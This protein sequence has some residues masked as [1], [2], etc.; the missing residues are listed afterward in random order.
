MAHNKAGDVYRLFATDDSSAPIGLAVLSNVNRIRKTADFWICRFS[1]A[2]THRRSKG[3][4]VRALN[5]MMEHAFVDLEL[6]VLHCFCCRTQRSQPA[7][8]R[9]SWM[10]SHGPAAP[11][12]LDE[13]TPL[14]DRLFFDMLREEFQASGFG[15]GQGQI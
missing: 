14:V 1:A 7:D 10:A 15:T 11:R 2:R 8:V 3:Y 9:K 4:G 6:D 12:P 13:W 5:A